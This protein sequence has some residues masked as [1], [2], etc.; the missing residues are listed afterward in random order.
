MVSGMKWPNVHDCELVLFCDLSRSFAAIATEFRYRYQTTAQRKA[1]RKRILR[2][3]ELQVYQ[4][5]TGQQHFQATP[6]GLE[7]ARAEK[8]LLDRRRIKRPTPGVVVV[9]T[10][11]KPPGRAASRPRT[12]KPRLPRRRRLPRTSLI[13]RTTTDRFYD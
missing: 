12:P 3:R 8:P 2:M 4:D 9:P 6:E 13:A 10:L 11:T 5:Q 1:L 7:W